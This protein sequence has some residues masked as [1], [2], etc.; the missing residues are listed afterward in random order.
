MLNGRELFSNSLSIG[1]AQTVTRRAIRMPPITSHSV[2]AWSNYIPV[3]LTDILRFGGDASCLLPVGVCIDA[4]V[5]MGSYVLCVNS[6][7][8]HLQLKKMSVIY[9]SAHVAITFQQLEMGSITTP[10]QLISNIRTRYIFQGV[11]LRKISAILPICIMK[12]I[13]SGSSV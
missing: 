8:T 9:E 10:N 6:L 12:K 1:P 11:F 2:T 13:K 7:I 3:F 5:M 4:Y